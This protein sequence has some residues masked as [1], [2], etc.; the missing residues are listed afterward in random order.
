MKN[1]FRILLLLAALSVIINNVYAAENSYDPTQ[2]DEN[3]YD[4]DL[5]NSYYKYNFVS[6]HVA[7]MFRYGEFGT[8]LFTG[9][10]QQTI[11]IYTLDDPDFKMNIALHYNAEGFKSRK[12]SGLVGYNWFLEAGGC[13]TR[14]VQGYPDEVYGIINTFAGNLDY[15]MGIEG[16]YHFI[17]N[18]RLGW[19]KSKEEI[20]ELHHSPANCKWDMGKY[21][22]SLYRSV[23]DVCDHYYID[24]QPDIF[25]FN[26]MG[27]KGTFIIDNNGKVQIVNGDFVSV[28]LSGI[29]DDDWSRKCFGSIPPYPKKNSTIIIKTTDGYTY[30]FGENLS[31]LEYTLGA[32]NNKL[33]LPRSP[34]REIRKVNPATVSTWY[35]SRIISP[36]GRIASF[37]YKEPYSTPAQESNL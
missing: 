17:A 32:Y 13:I 9:R 1:S 26:F 12:H 20:F 24:Y 18:K 4:P 19:D 34:E 8:S 5:A 2:V 6:P 28:D 15:E 25:H 22:D 23:G 35:L 33:F 11:P 10:M 3:T 31:K 29:L 21:S 30:Y 7:D 37:H 36:N 16:M 14:E 27:Y